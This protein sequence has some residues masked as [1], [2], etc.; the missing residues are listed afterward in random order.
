[1]QRR[2]GA[3][4]S[5]RHKRCRKTQSRVAAAIE[6]LLIFKKRRWPMLNG[7]RAAVRVAR[8]ENGESGGCIRADEMPPASARHK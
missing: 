5:A 2:G 1:M 6:A 8:L 3:Y 7:S 4:L